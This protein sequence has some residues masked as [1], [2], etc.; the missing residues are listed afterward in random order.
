MENPLQREEENRVY[1]MDRGNSGVVKVLRGVEI[2]EEA[3]PG[4]CQQP[5]KERVAPSTAVQARGQRDWATGSPQSQ[6]AER[7]AAP[8]P[9]TPPLLLNMQKRPC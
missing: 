6:L 2:R 1:H 3:Q 8:K 9:R 4:C 5:R 7:G